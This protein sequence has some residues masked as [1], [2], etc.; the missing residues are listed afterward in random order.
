MIQNLT[1]E[2]WKEDQF[3]RLLWNKASRIDRQRY[4]DATID[5]FHTELLNR[6][7]LHASLSLRNASLVY[8]DSDVDDD[9][10]I[11]EGELVELW[12]DCRMKIYAIHFSN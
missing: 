7:E 5:L 4:V 12:K 1:D 11:P 10:I 8:T 2:L 9:D 3:S 6:Y